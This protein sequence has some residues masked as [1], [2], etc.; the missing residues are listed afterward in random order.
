[1]FEGLTN[2]ASCS[3]SG[4]DEHFL[5]REELGPDSGESFSDS[6]PAFLEEYSPVV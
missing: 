4:E 5:V 3:I 1:V 2:L 6:L